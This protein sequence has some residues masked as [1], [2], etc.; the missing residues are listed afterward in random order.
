MNA[1]QATTGWGILGTGSIAHT[2]A[3]QL[4]SVPG[5][6]LAAVASRSRARAEAFAREVGADRGYEG[7]DA[8]VDDDGVDVVYVAT[9][10]VRHARDAIRALAAGRHVLCEKPLA[11]SAAEGEAM[12]EAAADAGRFLMEALWTRFLP[13]MR[14]FEGLVRD[15]AIGE[16]RLVRA[17]LTKV[18]SVAPTH[19]LR[20]P[21]LAGGALLDL[22]AY[23]V[24]L[25]QWFLGEPESAVG[26]YVED[27]VTGVDAAFTASLRRGERVAA[28]SSG[29]L[30]HGPCTAEV[31]GSAGRLLRGD[32]WHQANV[33][34][35]L[36]RDGREETVGAPDE[37]PGYAYEAIEVQARVAEGAGESAIHPLSDTLAVLRTMDRL[38]GAW[39]LRY[40][41][42]AAERTSGA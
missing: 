12:A 5:A 1:S 27:T 7:V 4:R 38:R 10:H 6:R 23:T 31:A 35:R 26:S 29:F 13:S 9:P 37:L 33:P 21:E 40:P 41:F 14:S 15:G 19:R 34:L 32:S 24:S 8:L 28:L 11:T 3:G 20:A 36:L 39:G 16:P 25:A 42:E 2:F 17:D 30:A 22:G 18:L